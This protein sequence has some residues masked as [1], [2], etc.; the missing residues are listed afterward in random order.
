MN[1]LIRVLFFLPIFLTANPAWAETVDINQADARAF[2]RELKGVGMSKA[3]AIVAYRNQYG[4]FLTV[5]DLS[6]VKGIGKAT[7]AKNRSKL[8]ITVPARN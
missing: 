7:V 2:A 4:P 1:R 5:D 6:L 8:T 3:Q